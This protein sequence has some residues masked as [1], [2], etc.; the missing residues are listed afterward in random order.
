MLFELRLHEFPGA[1]HR[2]YDTSRNFLLLICLHQYQIILVV[3]DAMYVEYISFACSWCSKVL[4]EGNTTKNLFFSWFSAINSEND[5]ANK[6]R[7]VL[8]GEFGPVP[9]T[10]RYYKVILYFPDKLN[11]CVH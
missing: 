2:A 3:F 8:T 7:N 11:C 1:G 5:E 9:A 10:A 4:A 6:V